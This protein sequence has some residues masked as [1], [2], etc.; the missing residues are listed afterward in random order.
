MA[1]P[2]KIVRDSAI[3]AE[4]VMHRGGGCPGEGVRSESFSGRPV[5]QAFEESLLLFAG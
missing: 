2:W 4:R 1:V 5:T 3:G